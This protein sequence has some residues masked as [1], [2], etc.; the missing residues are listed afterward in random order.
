MFPGLLVLLVCVLGERQS[1]GAVAIE[2][3]AWGD[4]WELT[5]GG[6]FA[7]MLPIYF[8]S[9]LGHQQ[10]YRLAGARCLGFGLWTLYWR[11]D[12]TCFDD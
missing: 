11:K 4:F 1:R 3:L 5:A 8:P 12:L 9:F 7:W 2:I 6:L 10:R